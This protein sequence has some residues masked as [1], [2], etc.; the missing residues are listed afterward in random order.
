MEKSNKFRNNMGINIP[1]V[2]YTNSEYDD[3]C[4]VFFGE[5]K[6]YLPNQKVYVVSDSNHSAIP[7]E[8]SVIIYDNNDSY[9]DRLLKTLPQIQED[10]ILFLHEDMVLYDYPQINSINDYATYVRNNSVDSIKLIYVNG[11]DSQ[12]D[13]DN[14]LISNEYSKFSIQPTLIS[15]KN[16]L[17]LLE[18][19]SSKNIWEFEQ[20]VPRNRKDYMVKL[21]GEVKRGIYHYD[22]KVFPYICTAINKGKWNMSEYSKEL[23][24]IFYEYGIVPF[25][26]GIV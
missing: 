6:K 16:F 8:Y 17:S 25:E 5:L 20:A 3:V 13:L 26:R 9:V 22:S 23:D 14:T 19:I 24:K 21:G 15:P 11:N 1:L 12:F 10:V 18:S 7:D 2:V 4:N